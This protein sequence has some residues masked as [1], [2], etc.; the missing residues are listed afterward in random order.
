MKIY[1]FITFLVTNKKGS[2]V[3][4]PPGSLKLKRTAFDDVECSN[5]NFQEKVRFVDFQY[6]QYFCFKH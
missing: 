3:Y 5:L 1:N 6:F 4:T 2:K